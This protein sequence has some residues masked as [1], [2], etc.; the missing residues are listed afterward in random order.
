MLEM[1]L[2]QE[3]LSLV[4]EYLYFFPRVLEHMAKGSCYACGK[5][6]DMLCPGCSRPIC[7]NHTRTIRHR[8]WCSECF[9][10]Q[11]HRGAIISWLCVGAII[12]IGFIALLIFAWKAYINFI[13]QK[14]STLSD[15]FPFYEVIWP[16]WKKQ[17][18]IFVFSRYRRKIHVNA[19]CIGCACRRR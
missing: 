6:T 2:F 1:R 15:L 18:E 11:R 9:N 13:C 8:F 16:L 19:S 5:R 17:R 12:V 4:S 3:V 14:G 7:A 10:K